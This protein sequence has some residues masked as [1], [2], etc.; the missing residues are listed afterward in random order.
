MIWAYP[1]AP[2]PTDFPSTATFEYAHRQPLYLR[3]GVAAFGSRYRSVL[4]FGYGLPW[5]ARHP[6]YCLRGSTSMLDS[7]WLRLLDSRPNFALINTST[8]KFNFSIFPTLGCLSTSEHGSVK[9]ASVATTP[10]SE[11]PSCLF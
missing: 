3:R 6:Y 1:L 7:K 2:D 11:D 9:V 5:Q 8:A 4:R 10:R